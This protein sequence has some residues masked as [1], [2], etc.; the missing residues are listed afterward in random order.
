VRYKRTGLGNEELARL[1]YPYIFTSVSAT[2]AFDGDSLPRSIIAE[3][4]FCGKVCKFFVLYISSVA[5]MKI[6][7]FLRFS[8]T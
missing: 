4:R 5:C 7:L 6:H 3:L 2:S 1:I 8:L